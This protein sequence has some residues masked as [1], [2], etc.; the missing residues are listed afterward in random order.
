MPSNTNTARL[1]VRQGGVM[2]RSIK[3]VCAAVGSPSRVLA[4]KSRQLPTIFPSASMVSHHQPIAL[5]LK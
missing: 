2:G 5:L 1:R 4:Q 3:H